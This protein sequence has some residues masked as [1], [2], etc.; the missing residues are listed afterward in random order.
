VRVVLLKLGL[1]IEFLL[2]IVINK[3]TVPPW[4][5]LL[6]TREE[7]R[8]NAKKNL[9]RVEQS[10]DENRVH[11]LLDKRPDCVAFQESTEEVCFPE[12]TIAM[13]TWEGWEEKN[14]KEK[15]DRYTSNLVCINDVTLGKLKTDG[16]SN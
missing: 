15:N 14:D 5:T 3:H 12:F 9:D 11:F 4:S 2:F 1:L 8:G 13:D 10:S 16:F 6:Q 7:V